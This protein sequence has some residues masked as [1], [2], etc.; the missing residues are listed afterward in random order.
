MKSSILQSARVVECGLRDSVV[1]NELGQTRVFD[2]YADLIHLRVEME[3]NLISR[4]SGLLKTIGPSS[5]LENVRDSRGLQGNTSTNHW[6]RRL[7]RHE[8]RQTQRALQ[9]G[10]KKE[11]QTSLAKCMEKDLRVK[12][13]DAT[14]QTKVEAREKNCRERRDGGGEKRRC[15]E[16]R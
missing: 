12:E 13:C 1:L 16:P 2:P 5:L 10:P 4:G 7:E 9:P 8:S 15:R 3:D 6:P 14:E 11:K